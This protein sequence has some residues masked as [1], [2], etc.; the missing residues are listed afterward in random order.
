MKYVALIIVLFALIGGGAWWY[1]QNQDT[2]YS[3]LLDTPHAGETL[4]RGNA[5]NVSWHTYNFGKID[6]TWV[7]NT[8]I[9]FE[10]V[11][12]GQTSE[13]ARNSANIIV[14]ETLPF[15]E[16]GSLPFT[17][18]SHIP[19]G[20]YAMKIALHGSGK[21]L[22]NPLWGLAYMTNGFFTVK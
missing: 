16:T 21:N 19:V 2:S 20:E 8:S 3:V 9:R 1:I 7:T 6:P 12:E 22:P 15:T 14:T 10:L 13:E 18:P 17:V 4:M 11:S 5:Y